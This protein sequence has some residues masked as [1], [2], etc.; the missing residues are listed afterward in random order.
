MGAVYSSALGQPLVVVGETVVPTDPSAF[1]GGAGAEQCHAT[2]LDPVLDPATSYS[3]PGGIEF[4]WKGTSVQGKEPVEA[5]LA[6]DKLGITEGEGG[7]IEKVDV[8]GEI[9]Y[10]LKKTLSAV[11]GTKPFIYQYLNEATLRVQVDGEATAVEGWLFNEASF[12]SE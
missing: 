5:K 6:I 7:L 8:L 4:V 9:P 1:P 10:L 3:A 2:H 11:T 12:V